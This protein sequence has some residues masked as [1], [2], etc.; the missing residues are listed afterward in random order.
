MV[1]TDKH[2]YPRSSAVLKKQD[3]RKAYMSC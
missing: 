3:L 2:R 1:N